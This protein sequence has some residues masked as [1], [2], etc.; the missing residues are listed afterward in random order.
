MITHQQ[1]LPLFTV[2][3]VWVNTCSSPV[4]ACMVQV[5]EQSESHTR[6]MLSA[7]C[8]DRGVVSMFGLPSSQAS[9][10]IFL[11]SY[12]MSSHTHEQ[13][14][15]RYWSAGFFL[16]SILWLGIFGQQTSCFFVNIDDK[17]TLLVSIGQE[18]DW[19][20]DS[21]M[22]HPSCHHPHCRNG[23]LARSIGI[24]LVG[25]WSA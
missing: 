2:L 3:F 1:R 11:P 23:Q 4:C 22:L 16:L 19:S 20:P 7:E 15:V 13:Q 6:T 5:V 18:H 17:A 24:L 10:I 8:S 12:H 21:P 14:V 9:Y 25:Q